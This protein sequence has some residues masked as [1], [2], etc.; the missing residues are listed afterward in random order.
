MKKSVAHDNIP[1]TFI[2]LVDRAI[3]PFLIKVINASFD[4]GVFPNILKIAYVIPIYKSR[5]KQ[6]VNNYRPTS[7]LFPSSK[8]CE[9]SILIVFSNF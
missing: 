2:E 4:L 7:L 8:I 1:V 6:I 5:D 3:A 9:K